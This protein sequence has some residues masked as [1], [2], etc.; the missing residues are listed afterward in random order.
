MSNLFL[1]PRVILSGEGALLSAGKYIKGLGRKALVVTDGVMRKI[2]NLDKVT[3]MLSGIGTNFAVY[4]GVNS[5][6]CDTMVREGVKIYKSEN[7]DFLIALGGGSPIDT[8]KAISAVVSNGGDIDDY[9]GREIEKRIPPLVA[10]P[11]TAGTGSE[12]TQFTIITDTARDIKMLLKGPLLISDIAVI[13][14]Q[15]TVTAPKRVTAFTGLDALTH[16]IEAYTSKKAQPMS[17]TFALSAVQRI[18]RFLP[19]AYDNGNDI[20]AR[21][22]MSIAATQAGI[23]F[24]NSSVTLVH[25]MS[26]PIGALFHVPHGMSNAMLLHDCLEFAAEGTP[27][28]FAGLARAAGFC[29]DDLPDAQASRIFL[30][31][32]DKLCLKLKVEKISDY[33]KGKEEF[34]GALD[35]MA[36]DAL[37]SGS[38]ANTIRPIDKNDVIAIYK[39]L[40]KE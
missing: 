30:D 23:A 27:E 24:N 21:A 3:E 29:A 14:P 9:M 32:V 10:V 38:P 1:S 39:K 35:K 4:D 17:D 18:F 31:E 7:C 5:E 20:E 25:G 37:A 28:R 33:A 40:W 26:R 15:F 19:A 22:E 34:F 36:D 16:A 2:G 12:A 6:P 11:T 13:D 8:M